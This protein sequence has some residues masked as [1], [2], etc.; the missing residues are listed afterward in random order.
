M[1][2]HS[3]KSLK[4]ITLEQGRESRRLRLGWTW[5]GG[6]KRENSTNKLLKGLEKVD[7]TNV[8]MTPLRL[9]SSRAEPFGRFW[10]SSQQRRLREFNSVQLPN[11]FLLRRSIWLVG[12]ASNRFGER[13]IEKEISMIPIERV[14]VGGARAK[15]KISLPAEGEACARGT[16][17]EQNKTKWNKIK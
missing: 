16:N 9:R 5:V 12:G 10:F 6:V 7:Q 2:A 15:I 3:W 1:A 14:V 17:G 8:I 4:T 13:L 11:L